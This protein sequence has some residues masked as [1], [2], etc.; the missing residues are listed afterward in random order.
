MADSR[1]VG[2][3]ARGNGR[4]GLASARASVARAILAGTVIAV[5]G[6]VGCV[7]S[8][9]CPENAEL[10]SGACSAVS[11]ADAATGGDGPDGGLPLAGDDAATTGD[12]A[13]SDAGAMDAA[14]GADASD[15]GACDGTMSTRCWEDGDGD[16]FAA[17]EAKGTESCKA[18]CPTK[19]TKRE[20]TVASNDCR[21][22]D[23]NAQPGAVDVCNDLDDD[24]DGSVDERASAT[25]E[26]EHAGGACTG[27]V[28]RLGICDKGYD[29]CNTDDADGCEQA[30]NVEENCG[31]CGVDCHQLAS[32][33]ATA[34]VGECACDAPSFGDGIVCLGIGPMATGDHTCSIKTDSSVACWG[35]DQKGQATPPTQNSGFGQ[36]AAA[37]THTCGLKVDGTIVCWGDDTFGQ[38]TAPEGTFTQVVAGRFHSCG[39]KTNGKPVCWGISDG[40]GADHGQTDAPDEVFRQLA[41]GLNH[42]CGLRDD[43][44]V[45]CWGAGAVALVSCTTGTEEC[46]QSSPPDPESHRFVQLT[47]GYW[48]TCG[49]KTNGSVVCWGRGLTDTDMLPDYGQSAPPLGVTFS[50]ISA[51]GVHTCG[52]TTSGAV[53][54]WGAGDFDGDVAPYHHRQS[55][56]P[57]GGSYLRV[58]GGGVHTCALT[59]TLAITCWGSNTSG[60]APTSVTGTWPLIP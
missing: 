15:A 27:G 52:V 22:L 41:A 28:C 36:L 8:K 6:H 18:S 13:A 17:L 37:A 60:Q 58:Y 55:L 4:H 16:G 3:V 5:L 31:A 51:G 14:T 48:H 49:L 20:P 32:C 29:D 34:S 43:G 53:V 59:D 46:G 56:P 2:G 7:S 10:A 21:P 42:T 9:G 26:H 1:V 23:P 35:N 47:A 57:S 30:L 25:C 24:C 11:E 50:F 38:A 19:T 40:S 33:D 54:C 12:A 44:S 39:L 45:R